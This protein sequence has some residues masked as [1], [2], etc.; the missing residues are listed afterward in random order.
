MKELLSRFKLRQ[1][2]YLPKAQPA[3]S[4]AG[5]SSYDDS[6]DAAPAG[7]SASSVFSKY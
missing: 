6:Y 3:Y 1:D 5:A 2:G 7:G 4:A